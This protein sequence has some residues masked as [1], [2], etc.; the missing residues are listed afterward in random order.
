MS[1]IYFPPNGYRVEL[2]VSL[3]IRPCSIVRRTKDE[4][5]QSF[6]QKHD[7]CKFGANV[8]TVPGSERVFL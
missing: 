8:L 4:S 6:L 5:V 3:C 7:A 1:Y 2:K